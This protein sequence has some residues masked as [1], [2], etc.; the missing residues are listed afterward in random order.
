[1]AKC[2]RYELA[3]QSVNADLRTEFGAARMVGDVCIQPRT[4]LAELTIIDPICTP[5]WLADA[6][7]NGAVA[8]STTES[9]MPG[10]TRYEVAVPCRIG[11]I[12]L[13]SGTVVAELTMLHANCDTTWWVNALR[14]GLITE[15]TTV[16]QR[17]PANA[18]T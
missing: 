15:S 7:R 16:P 12:P 18:G 1:M 5:Q 3:P 9:P 6:I 10:C 4:V 11:D 2:I 8:V 17:D 14:S 13:R